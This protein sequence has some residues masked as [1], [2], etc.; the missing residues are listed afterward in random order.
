MEK[1]KFFVM[2]DDDP[3]TNIFHE[4]ILKEADV[5]EDYRF[6]ESPIEA[7]SFFK[8]EVKNGHVIIPSVLFLD[9]NMPG[10][11]GWEFLDELLKIKGNNTPVIIMLTTSLSASDRKRAEKYDVI[12]DFCNKPLTVKYL[13]DLVGKI[14]TN[15]FD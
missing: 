13:H 5:C 14:A 8:N 2:I 15:S 12:K 3:V 11:S 10:I 7:L 1:L 6:Y 9:V 4:I